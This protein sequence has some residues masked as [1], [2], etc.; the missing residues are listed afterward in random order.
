[1]FCRCFMIGI[2][3]IMHTY[4]QLCIQSFLSVSQ[5]IS[6]DLHS[7]PSV[8]VRLHGEGINKIHELDNEYR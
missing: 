4:V 2:T 6:D 3:P 8:Q 5:I 1:M 7:R